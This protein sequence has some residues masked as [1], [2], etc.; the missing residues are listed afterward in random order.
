LWALT[1]HF[2]RL[3]A[4]KPLSAV[5]CVFS[6]QRIFGDVGWLDLEENAGVAEQ[7]LT[8]R[9]S[10]GKHEHGRLIL[11]YGLVDGTDSVLAA[12][13]WRTRVSA[14]HHTYS[15]ASGSIEIF[16][17]PFSRFSQYFLTQAS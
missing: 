8:A 10:G 1:G 15:S 4:G 12:R 17:S 14:P 2:V 16:V 13:I 9:R 6:R 7:F 11:D 3:L 5:S